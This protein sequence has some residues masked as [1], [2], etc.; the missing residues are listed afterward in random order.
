MKSSKQIQSFI[1]KRGNKL[2][3]AQMAEKLEV[4]RTTFAGVL[5]AMKRRGEISNNFLKSD[6]QKNY[7]TV[8]NTVTK[9]VSKPVSRVT[10]NVSKAVTKTSKPVSRV[11]NNVSKPVSKT[12]KPVSR[13]TNNV[14][15]A[16]T[17]T[18]KPVSRVT[19]NVSK[20][21]S[22]VTAKT[23]SKSV[24]LLIKK[25]KSNWVSEPFTAKLL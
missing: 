23:T 11:T 22:K 20:P 16:V 14:S 2:T 18:S 12:S 5:G 17:K 1:L 8:S 24:I 19:N 13:V 25:L 4:P 3:N 15:K 7:K 6:T 10:N 21:V 9:T